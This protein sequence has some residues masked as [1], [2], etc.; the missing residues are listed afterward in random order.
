MPSWYAAVCSVPNR[1]TTNTVSRE[2]MRMDR[3][4]SMSQEPREST[5]RMPVVSGA[6]RTAC[7]R[8]PRIMT[9]PSAAAMPHWVR[10]VP[11]A[12]PATP[13]PTG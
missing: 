13:Q 11:V 5:E 2:A 3:V 4:R 9:T 6:Q 1:A 8:V 10:E 12:E 7:S